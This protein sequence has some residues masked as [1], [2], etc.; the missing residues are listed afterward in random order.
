MS[1]KTIMKLARN[2]KTHA[3]ICVALFFGAML[4]GCS[5]TPA[6]NVVVKPQEVDIPIQTFCQMTDPAKPSMPYDEEATQ[7]MSLFNKV[8]LLIAQDL[9]LK[10]YVQELQGEVNSC[11]ASQVNTLPIPTQSLE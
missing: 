5:T 10:G 6:P 1:K 3:L 11:R 7:S 9:N 8:K 4:S 2:W